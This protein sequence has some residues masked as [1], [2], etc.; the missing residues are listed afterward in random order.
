AAP[1]EEGLVEVWHDG[2]YSERD[3]YQEDFLPGAVVPMPKPRDPGVLAPL[4]DGGD[5]LHYGHFSIKMHAQ[6][7]LALL[8]ASNVTAEPRL[9]RP[10]PGYDYS[11]KA[12]ADLGPNDQEK[13]FPD[14]RLAA[15]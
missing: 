14:P 12:L 3:G 13:W 10:E 1:I 15:E 2:D 6:R 11:R 9:K 5:T 4:L 8:T 7:R